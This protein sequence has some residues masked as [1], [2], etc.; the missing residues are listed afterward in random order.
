MAKKQ[1]ARSDRIADQMQRELADIIRT[2]LKD[3]R[4]GWVTLTAVEV[5][6]DYS[7]AKVFYTVMNSTDLDT[8]QRALEH[9]G[10]FLRS[11]V[12]RRIKLFTVPQLHFIYDQSIERGMHMTQ[13]INRVAEADQALRVDDED[14]ASKPAD[15]PAEAE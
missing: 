14:D 10:G 15:K 9:A 4:V 1:F 6:R 7:H 8:T 3:P 12:S 2:E 13:L 5:T 11:E